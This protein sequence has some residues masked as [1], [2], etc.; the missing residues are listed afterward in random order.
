MTSIIEMPPTIITLW[1]HNAAIILSI[2]VALGT[3]KWKMMNSRTLFARF[4]SVEITSYCIF[5]LFYQIAYLIFPPFLPANISMIPLGLE[6]IAGAGFLLLLPSGLIALLRM[7]IIQKPHFG[8]EVD[9][10]DVQNR[11][12]SKH[13]G[14]R[15]YFITITILAVLFFLLI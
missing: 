7:P 14:F 6:A 3:V 1:L 2:A 9:E 4:F 5:Y 8:P 10:L 15:V 12:D 13:M 11:L